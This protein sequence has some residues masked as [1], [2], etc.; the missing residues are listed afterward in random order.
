MSFHYLLSV[1]CRLKQQSKKNKLWWPMAPHQGQTA[2]DKVSFHIWSQNCHPN[3]NHYPSIRS[4]SVT[5]PFSNY[6]GAE[7]I[8]TGMDWHPHP[9][10]RRKLSKS[11]LQT[12]TL[13]FLSGHSHISPPTQHTL[14]EQTGAKDILTPSLIPLNPC[15]H[16]M[17]IG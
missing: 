8:W 6:A 17:N 2:K 10:W 9:S 12:W 16:L 14:T 11:W 15:K 1:E 13:S 4:R 3:A 5:H 7:R